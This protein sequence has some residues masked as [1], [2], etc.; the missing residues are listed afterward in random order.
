M[1]NENFGCAVFAI[2]AI[3][4]AISTLGVFNKQE[5]FGE[6]TGDYLE[7]CLDNESKVLE[8]DGKYY[9]FN[10]QMNEGCFTIEDAIGRS[11]PIG[12]EEFEEFYQ[13]VKLARIYAKALAKYAHVVDLVNDAETLVCD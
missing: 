7:D 3:I 5:G 6:V 8:F 12:V 9:D 2:A 13:A 1:A 11:V 4:L 10:I